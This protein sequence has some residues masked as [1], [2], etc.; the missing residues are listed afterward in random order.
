MLL[1]IC[2]AILVVAMILVA[3]FVLARG[4]GSRVDK[5]FAYFT[6]LAQAWICVN[7]I[8]ANFKS[9]SFAQYFER[10]DFFSGSILPLIIWLFSVALVKQTGKAK[11]YIK[12][13]EKLGIPF[14]IL[15]LCSAFGS[16]S[17]RDVVITY[18]GSTTNTTYGKFF[19]IFAFIILAII[20]AT[21]TNI[22]VARKVAQGAQRSQISSMV[23]GLVAA[24]SFV[25]AANLLVPIT[26]NSNSANLLA[27]NLSY[28]GIALFV[29]ATYYSIVRHKLFDLRLILART[30]AYGL[31][32]ATFI[33]IYV[34]LAFFISS[35]A[36]KGYE[37]SAR[38]LLI[39][40]ALMILIVSTVNP[41]R[42]FF[43]KKTNRIFYRNAYDPQTFLDQFNQVIIDN[44]EL[45]ILLR[46]AARIIE[47]NLN[48]E[49][50]TF[51][52][53]DDDHKEP[54]Y[55][56]STGAVNGFNDMAEIR[57]SFSK[58]KNRIM[59]YDDLTVTASSF[60]KSLRENHI[61]ILASLEPLNNPMKTANYLSL[62]DKKS[63]NP[64]TK[65]DIKIIEIIS[66][67][68]VI[69][70]QNAL[71]FEEIQSFN[72]TLQERIN[73]ATYKLRKANEKL[74]ALDDAKDDFISM[75][76]HQLRTPLTSV[77]GYISMVLEG[78]F[79]KITSQQQK[80]LSQA[81]SS[82]QRMAYVI[83]DL[84]N[85]SRLRT[86]KFI[87]ESVPANLADI[88]EQEVSQLK[89]ASSARNISL[90]F[91]KPASFPE[92]M[93]DETKTRQVIMNFIDNAIYYTPAKGSITLSLKDKPTVVELRIKDTG[94]G[95]P[96]NEQQHLFTK[97]YRAANARKARPD[98]TGL[99]LFMA[100]KVVIA[101]GGS[102][103]FE[104]H[105]G[106]GSTFGFVL[107]K[108]KL[109]KIQ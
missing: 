4:S 1:T 104:S 70:I 42:E 98:G 73:K 28:I 16:F 58:I 97:F 48:C 8:G 99:G 109:Q 41:F 57:D 27:G 81:F 91:E 32:L 54:R 85:V 21:I 89:D 36:V 34:G 72:A 22:L 20:A 107:N 29:G 69:A 2:V 10:A 108:A 33:A 71:R 45:G 35:F 101:Q 43:N 65:N 66:N 80:L 59:V 7:Y 88:V 9:H 87:M 31:S 47:E 51:V 25:A 19:V 38:Q 82:S 106:K 78:D 74:E 14:L 46:H 50:V 100:K 102:I 84:L 26:T 60:K 63:G 93:L 37:T 49:H 92:L 13:Q 77:K 90:F 5:T 55:I 94:I 75:A 68:L 39:T 40:I 24:V 30:I 52:L 86:G 44:I 56:G 15:S 23:V 12:F 79:G 83:S 67:E 11:K 76:S 61:A 3:T 95:V 64:F 53:Y 62:G 103:I 6:F 17:K 105:E 18:T 96:R